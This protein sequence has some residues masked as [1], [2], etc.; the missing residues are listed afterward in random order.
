LPV[1]AG[2]RRGK[3]KLRMTAYSD[4]SSQASL[5]PN[6]DSWLDWLS[7]RERP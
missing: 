7:W 5:Y 4:I 1:V 3:L 6:L 2:S